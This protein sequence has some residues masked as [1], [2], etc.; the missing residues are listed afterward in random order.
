MTQSKILKGAYEALAFAEGQS[1]VARR[2]VVII[3]AQ[4][5]VRQIRENLA[6][7]QEEFSNRFGFPLG[8]IRNWEQGHRKPEGPARILLTVI[9]KAPDVVMQALS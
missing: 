3:P 6:M 1:G 2:T 9:A 7:T 5:N 8:T 4:V